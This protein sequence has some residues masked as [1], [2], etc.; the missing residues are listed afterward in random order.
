MEM[1]LFSAQFPIRSSAVGGCL[2]RLLVNLH[3][4]LA[5]ETNEKSSHEMLKRSRSILRVWAIRSKTFFSVIPCAKKV[6]FFAE[7]IARV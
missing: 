1:N 2:T 7:L 4:S 3:V 5:A 6:A